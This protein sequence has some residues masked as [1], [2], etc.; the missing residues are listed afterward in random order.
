MWLNPANIQKIVFHTHNYFSIHYEFHTFFP[1]LHKF[2]LVLF[3][4]ILIYSHNWDMHIEHVKQALEILKR[5]KFFL[6]FNKCVFGQQ[7]IE[8]LLHI[9]IDQRVKV[10]QKK[11]RMLDWP[12]LA[13][14]LELCR[15]IGI[16][17]NIKSFFYNYRILARPL[18][19]LLKIAQLMRTSQ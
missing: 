2:I 12:Q 19:N 1:Y 9:I 15:F 8:Y 10:N 16:Q 17:D 13:N 6:K 3:D 11:K 14:V 18:S 7:K 5:E 4:D